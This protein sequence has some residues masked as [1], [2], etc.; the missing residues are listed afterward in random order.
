MIPMDLFLVKAK[1]MQPP[2]GGTSHTCKHTC[3]PTRAKQCG[4]S[5]RSSLANSKGCKRLNAKV[6]FGNLGNQLINCDKVYTMLG[7]CADIRSSWTKQNRASWE[8]AS[9]RH[10][11]DFLLYCYTV[12]QCDT[13]TKCLEVSGLTPEGT[14][15]SI[16]Y[17]AGGMERGALLIRGLVVGFTLSKKD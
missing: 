1:Q 13:C 7:D 2:Q 9:D 4:I 16:W 5:C 14:V 15:P 3:K 8:T 12:T 6:F 17:I 11:S 10:F